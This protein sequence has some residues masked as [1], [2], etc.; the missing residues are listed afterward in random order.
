M[1][2]LAITY[3][4]IVFP[5]IIYTWYSMDKAFTDRH[6]RIRINTELMIAAA[7]LSSKDFSELTK[8][9]QDKRIKELEKD[10]SKI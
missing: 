10:L 7:G 3:A 8:E 5:A 4:I 2:I 1:N 9:Q 6:K